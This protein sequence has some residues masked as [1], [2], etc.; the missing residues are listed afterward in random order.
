[1]RFTKLL[2]LGLILASTTSLFAGYYKCYH[3]VNGKPTGGYVK[4]K[5][6]SKSYAADKAMQ[7]Y[8]DMGK[9]TD[10]VKCRVALL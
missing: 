7:K 1:M 3:Y 2:F 8:K 6:S 5:A 10:Y 4:V 9:R